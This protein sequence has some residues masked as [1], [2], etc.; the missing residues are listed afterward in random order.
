MA[1]DIDTAF[2]TQFE[3]EVHVAYQ[4]MG[5]K[6][7]NT[8]RNVN[9]VNGSTVRFQKVAAGTASTKA[10]HSS[11]AAMDLDHSTVDA[12]LSDYYAADYVDQ[13][14]ELKINIDERQVVAM[15]AAAALGRKTDELITT[16]MDSTTNTIAHGSNPL[17]S[18]KVY[19]AFEG[20]G[21]NDIPDD[22]QRFAAVSPQAWTD[23]LAVA[24][25]TQAEYIGYD[26]LPHKGGMTAKS[27]LGFVWFVHS[28]LPLDSTTRKCFMYHRSAIGFGSGKDVNTEINYI[29]EKVSHL[30]TASLS[31]GACLFD[32]N[33]IYEVQ[34]TES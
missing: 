10:R 30:I 24:A 12:T 11:V 33:G 14:D 32:A 28:G 13:L 20:L 7:R 17:N 23:L 1:L 6:L 16:A 8:V 2:I 19:Q 29:P 34:V 3:S 15:N 27:W 25:F 9:N 31:Q 4:R 22:G 21:E 26:D 18:T 5:S